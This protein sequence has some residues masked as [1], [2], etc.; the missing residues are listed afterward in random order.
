MLTDK[1]NKDFEPNRSQNKWSQVLSLDWLGQ[2]AA[3]VL[4]AVS[5][6]VYGI[7]SA[8][9]VLQLCAA[10]AWIVANLAALMNPQPKGQDQVVL[11]SKIKEGSAT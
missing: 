2:M 9:D 11:T 6:F 1:E 10:L 8:G 4:W 5:V 3:S 7:T